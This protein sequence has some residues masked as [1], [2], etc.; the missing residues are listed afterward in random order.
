MKNVVVYTTFFLCFDN[1]A[2]GV[3][4]NKNSDSS[5][6]IVLMLGTFLESL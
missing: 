3:V 1:L 5:K 2:L 6:I 4:E